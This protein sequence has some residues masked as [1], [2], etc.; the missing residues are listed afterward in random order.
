MNNNSKQEVDIYSGGPVTIEYITAIMKAIVDGKRIQYKSNDALPI[1][2]N[3]LNLSTDKS[4]AIL[5]NWAVYSY[6]VDPTDRPKKKVP[7][8][9]SD[10][11][12]VTWFRGP[13]I[14]YEQMVIGIRGGYLVF[15][16]DSIYD[17]GTKDQL[18]SAPWLSCMSMFNQYGNYGTHEYSTDRKTWKPTHKEVDA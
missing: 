15:P 18:K 5:L 6:R 8:D 16:P 14:A 11:G 2:W 4:K 13:L 3:N 17:D 12:P 1:N 10:L 9:I 7:L